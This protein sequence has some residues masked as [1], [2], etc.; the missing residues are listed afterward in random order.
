MARGIS[1]LEYAE[2]KR[3]AAP[4]VKF[5]DDARREPATRRRTAKRRT[6]KRRVQKSNPYAP[7]LWVAGIGAVL[8]IAATIKDNMPSTVKGLGQN[9]Q[10]AQIGSAL[11]NALG[12][13]TGIPGLGQLGSVIGSLFGPSV[14]TDPMGVPQDTVQGIFNE[15]AQEMFSTINSKRVSYGLSPINF[16]GIPTPGGAAMAQWSTSIMAQVLY[17]PSLTTTSQ[18]RLAQLREDGTMDAAIAS[19]QSIIKGL[20]MP[21][22]PP[23]APPQNYATAQGTPPA[24]PPPTSYQGTQQASMTAPNLSTYGPYIAGGLLFLGLLMALW[25]KE[26]ADAYT[27]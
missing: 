12:Q 6:G 15:T 27:P 14:H 23:A 4:G 7:A 5:S 19:M 24:A 3:K 2:L 18:D 21:A 9:A 22:P 8:G 1:E 16:P 25:R 26:N 10:N 17:E 11:G 13:V 20:Q